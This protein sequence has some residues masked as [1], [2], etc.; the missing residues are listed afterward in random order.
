MWRK[1][2][3]ANKAEINLPYELKVEIK[4]VQYQLEQEREKAARKRRELE[5]MSDDE[6][7]WLADPRNFGPDWED[8]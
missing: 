5:E 6:I 1:R 7:N 2:E 4:D 8:S 3:I